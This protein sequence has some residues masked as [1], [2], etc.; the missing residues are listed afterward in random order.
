[1]SDSSG[2]A[3]DQRLVAIPIDANT[4]GARLTYNST[5]KKIE[6]TQNPVAGFRFELYPNYEGSGVP[7]A[8]SRDSGVFEYA[9]Q[10]SWVWDYTDANKSSPMEVTQVSKSVVNTPIPVAF[11]TPTAPTS[12]ETPQLKKLL[13]PVYSLSGGTY[14]LEDFPMHLE[15]IYPNEA[16]KIIFGLV[17]S[18]NW[19]WTYYTAPILVT[20]STQIVAFVES[21][22]P[23][24]YHNSA[25]AGS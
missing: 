2:A 10:S 19:T 4:S 5:K 24:Q 3:I 16:G 15:I 6:L 20:P 11:S 1:M 25:P 21:W 12:P 23:Q 9:N 14:Q 13:S 7:Q 22:R 18:G 17:S 8:E